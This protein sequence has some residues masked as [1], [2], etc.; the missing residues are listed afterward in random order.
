MRAGVTIGIGMGGFVDGIVLHQILEWHNMGSSVLP[1]T[2]MEAMRQNMIWDGEFHAAVWLITL[3][4]V[5]LLVADARG[6]AALPTTGALCGQLLLGWGLFNVAEGIIDH[7]LLNLHHVRDL[8]AHVPLYD[9]LFLAIGGVG[10]V[11]VGWA[12]ARRAR[13]GKTR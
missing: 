1:P 4:G 2:T 10:F 7:H 8:P 13:P 6:G 9:W 11:L 5:H 3:I 12:L